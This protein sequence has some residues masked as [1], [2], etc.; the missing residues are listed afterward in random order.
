MKV[1]YN[2]YFPFKGRR[3]INL[4]GLV[5][6]REGKHLP[7][8]AFNRHEIY[9]AQMK[10]LLYIGFYICYVVEW[11]YHFV[12]QKKNPRE[13]ISFEVEAHKHQKNFDY[14]STRKPFAQ[15]RE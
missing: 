12:N 3:S 10:E 8:H 5:F 4:F 13:L 11:L 6:V 2:K 15:W 9:I 14:V 1:I 7:L